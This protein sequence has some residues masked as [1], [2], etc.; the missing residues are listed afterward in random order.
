MYFKQKR[1]FQTLPFNILQQDQITPN[2][3]LILTYCSRKFLTFTI[4][5]FE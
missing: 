3:G 1:S 5:N 4:V 2:C